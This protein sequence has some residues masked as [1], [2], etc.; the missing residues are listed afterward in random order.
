MKAPPREEG[1]SLKIR[2][3]EGGTSGRRKNQVQGGGGS[4]VSEEGGFEGSG[5]WGGFVGG[6]REKWVKPERKGG[7]AKETALRA[8]REK[9]SLKEFEGIITR[10]KKG[11]KRGLAVNYPILQG[12]RRCR[13]RKVGKGM[14]GK[15]KGVSSM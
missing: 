2:K 5:G 1:V 14:G 15:G 4:V 8:G 7:R 3:K 13:T 10:G 6:G 9:A 12:R 11:L